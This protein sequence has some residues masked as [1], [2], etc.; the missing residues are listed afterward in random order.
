MV[1]THVVTTT[2]W[3]QLYQK[4]LW[5][6]QFTCIGTDFKH[7]I[8]SR[9]KGWVILCQYH[10]IH[11]IILK[12]VKDP[13]SYQRVQCYQYRR[14]PYLKL[15]CFIFI[16]V[17]WIFQQF[18]LK[19]SNLKISVT[20]LPF[21]QQTIYSNTAK[22]ISSNCVIQI[23]LCILLWFANASYCNENKTSFILVGWKSKKFMSL[24]LSR[25]FLTI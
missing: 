13:F 10:V 3:W 11:V 18:I 22:S 16:S 8:S 19:N 12:S 1:D 14:Y 7:Y 21:V 17:I 2:M 23:I 5:F 20:Q 6:H 4:E 24:S 15:F 9:F 25:Y